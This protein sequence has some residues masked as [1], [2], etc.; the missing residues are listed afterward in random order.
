MVGR[1]ISHYKILS[2]L[3]AGG[4]GVVYK[5]E[6]T[7]LERPVALKFLNLATDTGDESRARFE[8]E[9][10]AAAALDH[11]NICTVYEIDEAEGRP[12]IAM[13]FLEG[14]TVQQ[15]AEK[16]PLTIDDVLELGVQVAKGLAAAHEKGVVHRDIK[17]ANLMVVRATTGSEPQLKIMDFGLAQLAAG[18]AK[19]TQDGSTL[20]TAA[21]MSPEQ[22][23]GEKVDQRSD[24]WSLGVV[25]HEMLTGQMPFRGEYQQAVVYSILHEE[26]QPITALRSG[27]DLEL[28]RIVLK[29]LQKDQEDRYQS[30]V[31]LLV[32][33][34]ALKKQRDSGATQ[35]GKSAYVTAVAPPA[36]AGS[37]MRSAPTDGSGSAQRFSRWKQYGIIGVA[38]VVL[39][40]L[41][42]LATR[43][44]GPY[45]PADRS[46]PP[47]VT[48]ITSDAGTE[49]FATFSPDGSQVAFVWD[50]QSQDNPDIYIRIVHEGGQPLRLTSDPAPESS[51]A[52]SPDGRS[53]AFVRHQRRESAVFLVPPIGGTE[54][55]LTDIAIRG[56]VTPDRL[57]A[58]SPDGQTLAIAQQ[59]G[60]GPGPGGPGGGPNGAWDPNAPARARPPAEGSRPEQPPDRPPPDR[61]RDPRR[62]G[63]PGGIRLYDVQSG[64]STQLDLTGMSGDRRARVHSPVFSPDGAH[65]AFVQG[66]G[67]LAGDIYVMPA[68]GGGTPRPVTDDESQI[69]GLAWAEDG[70]IVFSSDRAGVTRLWRARVGPLGGAVLPVLGPGEN[71]TLPATA[72]QGRRLAY[73]RAERDLNVWQ[74]DVGHGPDMMKP[75]AIVASTR[76]D[77]S[78]QFSSDGSRIAFVSDRSGSN[79]LWVADAEGSSAVKL[80]SYGGPIVASPSWSPDGAEIALQVISGNRF[81]VDVV[82]VSGSSTRRLTKGDAGGSL[83]FWSHD[84]EWIYVTLREDGLCKIPARGGEVVHESHRLASEGGSAQESMDGTLLYFA[85]RRFGGGLWQVPVEGGAEIALPREVMPAGRGRWVVTEKGIFFIDRDRNLKVYQTDTGKVETLTTME[86]EAMEYPGPGFSVSPDGMYVLYV[87]V[88][89]SEADLMLVD[90]YR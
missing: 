86:P 63:N 2:R 20:G 13:A 25:L 90:N 47:A 32:D 77:H 15:L 75:K 52:W 60:P 57:L 21:Y 65:L 85:K 88:D 34:R 49:S 76:Q 23:R 74:L 27:V 46:L 53:I 58:W 72:K 43:L 31:D 80:T 28:E 40:T 82:P 26:P 12:F 9:A 61:Q 73:T 35:V 24:L 14:E 84:G 51:P 48:P 39:V 56:R 17:S 1:T 59:G 54:R 89:R 42:A 67:P 37:A 29:T 71:A 50:G 11:P 19:L 45:S 69:Q 33:L 87:R 36:A 18:A 66:A 64:Q 22:S 7:R 79:E 4:M 83:P 78:P 81:D 10:R 62:R 16:S 8:R 38:A 44:W 30:A 55:K 41:G 70:S 68:D 5:A 3:G 6:D